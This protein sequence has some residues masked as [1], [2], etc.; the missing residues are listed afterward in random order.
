MGEADGSEGKQGQSQVPWLRNL[1]PGTTPVW[2]PGIS[3][4]ALPP[5]DSFRWM[6]GSVAA[7]ADTKHAVRWGF[8][9][10][11]I[12]KLGLALALARA[13]CLASAP[14]HQGEMPWVRA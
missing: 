8:S 9:K 12:P 10:D 4:S 11:S 1:G 7:T 5:P 6:T 2:S 14:F 3:I 13:K